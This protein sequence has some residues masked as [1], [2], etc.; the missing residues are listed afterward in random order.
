MP[1]GED[2][3]VTIGDFADVGVKARF[4]LIAIVFNAL[5]A[6]RVAVGTRHHPR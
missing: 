3:A 2:I 4:L 5:W 6:P 1:G